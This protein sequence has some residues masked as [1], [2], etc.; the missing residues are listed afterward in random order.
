MTKMKF[1]VKYTN[2]FKRDVKLAMKRGLDVGLLKEIV[3]ML[4]DGNALPDKNKDH[5]LNGNWTGFRECHI[6]PNWVLIYYLEK[7][8]S[9]HYGA[10]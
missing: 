10:F 5:A 8:C 3:S 7:R 2:Q 4:A 1:T 9:M 6:L